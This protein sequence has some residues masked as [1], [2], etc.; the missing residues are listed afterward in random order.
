VTF[1]IVGVREQTEMDEEVYIDP[2]RSIQFFTGPQMLKV[3][4]KEVEAMTRKFH[5]L[6]YNMDHTSTISCLNIAVA[7]GVEGR[8][9]LDRGNFFHSACA[10]QPSRVREMWIAG[11]K[12]RVLKP[13]GA[14]FGVMHVKTIAFDDEVVLTGSVNLTH[15]GFENSKEQ[16][17]RI[18]EEQTVKEFVKDFEKTWKIAE[19]VT[20]QMIDKMMKISED[21]AKGRNP[22]KST[23]EGNEAEHGSGCPAAGAV[24]DLP[25]TVDARGRG[26]AALENGTQPPIRRT[27]SYESSSLIPRSFSWRNRK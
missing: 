14:G 24:P 23:A 21:K 10:R 5:A 9:V 27:L 2:K 1:E 12:M 6:Q 20:E 3:V 16:M 7:K 4:T 22:S 15:N 13:P 11:V 25:R 18:T 8:I 19:P 26:Q 17:V